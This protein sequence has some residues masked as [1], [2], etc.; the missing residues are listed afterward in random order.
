MT[1]F[2]AEAAPEAYVTENGAVKGYWRVRT[3]ID[4]LWQA[5]RAKREIHIHGTA[6]ELIAGHLGIPAED[7]AIQVTVFDEMPPGWLD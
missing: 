7:I 1:V 5:A 3:R 6:V 4:D 2:K